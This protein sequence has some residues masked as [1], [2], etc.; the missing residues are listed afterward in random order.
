MAQFYLTLPSN[1]SAKYFPDNTLT[2]FVTKLHSSVSLTSDWE[3]GLSEISFPKTWYNIEKNGGWITVACGGYS[4]PEIGTMHS[5]TS[6]VRVPAGYYE[7]VADVVREINK[8]LSKIIPLYVVNPMVWKEENN[9][10]PVLKYHEG[11]K[12]VHFQ[13]SRNQSISLSPTLMTILGVGNKQNPSVAKQED[14]YTWTASRGS[15]ISR[16]LNSIFLYC[17]ICEHVPIGDT[18]APLLRIV[19]TK[20]NHGDT[21]N[22]I[23]DHPRYVPIQKKQFESI[24]CL[25]NDDLGMKVP[26]QS[27]KVIVTLHLRQ[28][29]APYFL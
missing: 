13:M 26:F 10:M 17:D 15:D 4:S 16:G 28:A 12:R 22:H 1:S 21:I 8:T 19:D 23:Y 5:Y 14:T 29:K 7:S 27:G 24:E 11:T 25:I 20:G 3:V 18:R 6:E 2:H 9:G